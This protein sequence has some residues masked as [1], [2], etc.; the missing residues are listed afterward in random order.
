MNDRLCMAVVA[1]IVLL[2]SSAG[3]QVAFATQPAVDDLIKS[4][5]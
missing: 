2:F 4:L 1:V 3:L 5:P